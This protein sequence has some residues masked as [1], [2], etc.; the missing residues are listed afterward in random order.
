[1]NATV[2]IGIDDR[3]LPA[4]RGAFCPGGHW[5]PHFVNFTKDGVEVGHGD[6]DET[7]R[8]LVVNGA[9]PAPSHARR[10]TS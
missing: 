7:C 4:G 1:M 8:D 6:T 3:C 2:S 10:K 9:H 5:V